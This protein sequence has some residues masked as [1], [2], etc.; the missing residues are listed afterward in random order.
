MNKN[1]FVIIGVAVAAIFAVILFVLV[2]GDDT[3][4]GAED[5]DIT[6]TTDPTLPDDQSVT[7]E[8][9]FDPRET[10][11][12]YKKWAQYPPYSRPLHEGQVDLL[13]PY[14]AERPPIRVIS[15]R[16][17]GCVKNEDGTMKCEKEP[18]FSDI[19]C[20]MTPER[21]ISIGKSDFKVTLSCTQAKSGQKPELKKI[22]DITTKFYRKFDRQ[23]TH[24]LP[25]IAAGDDGNNGDAKANDNVYTILV[26]PTSKDWGWVFV[27]ANFKVDGLD[28][29]QR[30]NWF[31]TPYTV[32]E[33]QEGISDRL[34]DGSLVVSVPVNIRKAGYYNFQANLQEA[35][36]EKKFVA[37]AS[38]GQ[39]FETG[40]HTVDLVFFGKIIRDKKIDGPYIVR[41]IR[42]R[43]DNSPVPPD[44]LQNALQTGQTIPPQE[45]KEP[46][47]EYLEPLASDYTTGSYRAEDFSDREWESDQKE[48]RIQF[49]NRVASEG[50]DE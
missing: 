44:M 30:C 13:D 15:K 38:K 36:G 14:N 16:A 19:K 47:Y 45:H 12:R 32:A 8:E 39:R 50:T 2:Q 11:K 22:T 7:V 18:E 46:L 33:F 34:G 41:E 10:L 48:R 1:T 3:G 26:R 37:S 21:S 23:I 5:P 4:P 31:S 28:Q 20:E 35:G 17:E 49:L 27:E 6:A 29:V 9:S 24:S 25:P 43:R 42:G 40:Q